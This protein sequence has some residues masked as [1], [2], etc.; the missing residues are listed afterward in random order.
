[1][2]F[3]IVIICTT[4]FV[5]LRLSINLTLCA[6]QKMSEN[7][8][9]NNAFFQDLY[10]FIVLVSIKHFSECYWAALPCCA[11]YSAVRGGPNTFSTPKPFSVAHEPIFRKRCMRN[12]T[13]GVHFSK[14]PST[15]PGPKTIFWKLNFDLYN[16]VKHIA[17]FAPMITI[18]W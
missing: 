11:V 10:T 15:F 2:F 4:M 9:E 17:K 16:F 14:L 3:L 8:P 5:S 18:S 12:S 6:Y 1:M 13:P 7:S